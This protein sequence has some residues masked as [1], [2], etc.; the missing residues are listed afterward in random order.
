M[1]ND[2]KRKIYTEI[3]KTKGYKLTAPRLLV[4]DVFLQNRKP[5][6]ADFVYEKVRTKKTDRVTVYRTL[7]I[8]ESA[9]VIHQVN[10]KKDSVFFELTKDHHHHIVCLE[11]GLIEDFD[12]CTID[13][14]AKNVISKSPYFS[15]IDHHSL[16]LFAICKK[17]NKG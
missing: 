2:P 1:K 13:Q 17:C 5:L 6:N 11:C 16:E 3:L 9:R 14:L 12:A 15:S 8:F 7:K 10:L 4:L